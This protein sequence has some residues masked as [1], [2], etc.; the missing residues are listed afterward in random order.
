MRMRLR[1][2]MRMSNVMAVK[3][4]SVTKKTSHVSRSS[5]Y[6]CRLVVNTST[7]LRGALSLSFNSAYLV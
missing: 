7:R 2:K 6:E 4:A 1:K 3:M 5:R